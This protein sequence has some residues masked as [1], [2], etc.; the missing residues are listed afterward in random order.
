MT[1]EGRTRR[2]ALKESK[3]VSKGALQSNIDERN[4]QRQLIA[5]NHYVVKEI[6]TIWMSDKDSQK[7]MNEIKFMNKIHSN[8][9]VA[10]LDSY[11]QGTKINIIME[12]CQNGD[13]HTYMEKNKKPFA[14]MFIWKVFIQTCLGIYN[15]HS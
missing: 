4:R 2:V 9:I 11:A 6:E 15:L 7:M 1:E 3:K 8:F 14:S 13:L 10:Y 5:G 12:Y